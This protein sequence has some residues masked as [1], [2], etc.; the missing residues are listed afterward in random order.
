MIITIGHTKGGVGK[1]TLA[2]NIASA[3]FEKGETVA[4]VDLD[5]QQTLHFINE[6]RLS[7]TGHKFNLIQPQ[8]VSD[9]LDIFHNYKGILIVDIGGFDSDLNR[10]ALS[11]SDELIVPISNSIT[12]VLGFKTFENILK[13]IL[14][15]KDDLK[16]SV[17]LNNIHPLAKNFDVIKEAIGDNPMINLLKTV[18]RTRK[19][20]KES[21][22]QG[23]S[24]F[25]VKNIKAMSEIQ[26]VCDELKCIK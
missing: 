21:L 11:W 19:V 26:G 25:D 1:S 23:L 12:E 18:V 16:M 5:F 14:I 7:T 8:S 10:T 20:Y 15:L 3:L 13:E 4:I 6:I 2:F 17:V 22:G 24:V 9:L